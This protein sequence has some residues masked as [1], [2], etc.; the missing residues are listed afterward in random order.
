HCRSFV[1]IKMEKTN[2]L[3]IDPDPKEIAGFLSALMADWNKIQIVSN[4]IEALEKITEFPPDIIISEFH[5]M[6]MNGLE[7]CSVL[8]TNKQFENIPFVIYSSSIEVDLKKQ[9]YRAGAELVTEIQHLTD[10][11]IPTIQ[12]LLPEK[13]KSAPQHP[14]GGISGDLEQMS[15]IELIQSMDMNQKT[16]KL[17]LEADDVQGSLFFE[18]GKIIDEDICFFH[19]Y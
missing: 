15:L 13:I 1:S 18:K 19:F 10:K 14:P 2:I 16:G 6:D 9:C 17:I 8:K 12:S 7:L 4:G 11:M 5:L 3:I